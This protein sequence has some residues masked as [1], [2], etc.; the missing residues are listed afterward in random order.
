MEMTKE[1]VYL[2]TT[3]PSV[4]Y[5]T[6]TPERQRLTVQ[7]WHDS[8]SE[9][10]GVVSSIVLQEIRDTPNSERRAQMENLVKGLEELTFDEEANVLAQEYM[11]NGVFPEKYAS[12]ANHVA[13]AVTNNIGYF[14]SWNFRHMVKVKT[15]REVNRINELR[16]YGTIEII[17]PPEL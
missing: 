8:L 10:Q 16:G 7:F 4:Y 9:F 14:C 12:D 3:V 6:R 17:A 11:R 5:D 2:D 15:R 1:K 13:I